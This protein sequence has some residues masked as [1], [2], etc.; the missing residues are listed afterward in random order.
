MIDAYREDYPSNFIKYY[1]I[2]QITNLLNEQEIYLNNLSNKLK[3]HKDNK[4]TR[5]IIKDSYGSVD[6]FEYCIDPIREINTYK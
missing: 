2:K 5:N 3:T 1:D 6:L 4:S